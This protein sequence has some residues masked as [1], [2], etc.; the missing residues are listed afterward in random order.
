MKYICTLFVCLMLV[1]S[2]LPPPAQAATEKYET[3]FAL[4]AD[5]GIDITTDAFTAGRTTIVPIDGNKLLDG[6]TQ[7]MAGI[8]ENHERWRQS[9]QLRQWHGY[10]GS[11]TAFAAVGWDWLFSVVTAAADTYSYSMYGSGKTLPRDPYPPEPPK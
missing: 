3:N 7:T 4:T 2:S 11:S 5:T 1:A 6:A 10:D 8:L 9:Q